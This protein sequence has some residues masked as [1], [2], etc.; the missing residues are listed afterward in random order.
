MGISSLRSFYTANTTVVI[1]NKRCGTRLFIISKEGKEVC[2]EGVFIRERAKIDKKKIMTFYKSVLYCLGAHRNRNF[3]WSDPRLEQLCDPLV[4]GMP[5]RLTAGIPACGFLPAGRLLIV[6]RVSG[7][8]AEI[9]VG[10][11]KTMM[12]EISHLWLIGHVK[13]ERRSVC[14]RDTLFHHR[15]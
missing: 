14:H 11:E 7:V 1:Y 4:R 5:I 13:N 9:E 10:G 8:I 6:S 12:T 2:F 15:Q 3:V